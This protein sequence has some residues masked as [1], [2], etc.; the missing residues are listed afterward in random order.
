LGMEW[1]N[2]F[3]AEKRRHQLLRYRTAV[4]RCRM[5]G[6]GRELG[7]YY[8]STATRFNCMRALT[9]AVRS[10][11]G[12]TSNV[13]NL[14]LLNSTLALMRTFDV[15][16]SCCVPSYKA[17][18]EYY[19]FDPPLPWCAKMVSDLDTCRVVIRADVVVDGI[20]SLSCLFLLTMVRR[21]LC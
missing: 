17:L 9:T 5:K 2:V 16:S 19:L 13:V 6:S 14:V 21:G 10:F 20:V 18:W 12:T 11:Q 4:E 1:C 8:R 7:N 15:R 3:F